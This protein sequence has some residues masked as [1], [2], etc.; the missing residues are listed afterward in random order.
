MSG[1]DHKWY[2]F[3]VNDLDPKMRSLFGVPQKLTLSVWRKEV[4]GKTGVL[5]FS[6]T[7]RNATGHFTL[8]DKDHMANRDADEQDATDPHVNGVMFWE[9]P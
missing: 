7:W 2:L 5:K 4:A 1:A 3:R 9:V 8:W 6:A